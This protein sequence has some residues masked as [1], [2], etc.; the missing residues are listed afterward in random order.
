MG[1]PLWA[2]ASARGH[3]LDWLD[4]YTVWKKMGSVHIKCFRSQCTN[5][6]SFS[7]QAVVVMIFFSEAGVG[8]SVGETANAAE[9]NSTTFNKIFLCC[10]ECRE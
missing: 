3:Q 9:N 8:L 1:L 4:L 6:Q 10:W 7:R 5:A 2:K